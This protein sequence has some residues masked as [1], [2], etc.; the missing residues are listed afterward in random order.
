MLPFSCYIYAAQIYYFSLYTSIFLFFGLLSCN[1]Y[2]NFQIIFFVLPKVC[3][4]FTVNILY[5]MLSWN[6]S[7]MLIL[8]SLWYG[9]I[10]FSSWEGTSPSNVY[11]PDSLFYHVTLNIFISI[12]SYREHFSLDCFSLEPPVSWLPPPYRVVGVPPCWEPRGSSC[13]G[14]LSC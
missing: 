6:I 10:L 8:N 11:A 13:A 12:I 5:F 1:G 2:I 3:Y 7:D 9:S 14:S 4:F